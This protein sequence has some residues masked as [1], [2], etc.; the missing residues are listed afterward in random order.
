[1]GASFPAW[2]YA[3]VN[4]AWVPRGV[5]GYVVVGLGGL[6]ALLAMASV[7]EQAW[8][9]V[10]ISLGFGLLL[11]SAYRVFLIRFSNDPDIEVLNRPLVVITFINAVFVPVMAMYH[12]GFFDG[13]LG[14]FVAAVILWSAYY[15]LAFHHR[16]DEARTFVGLPSA[17]AVVGF[18]LS[19]FDATPVAAMTI[20][21]LVVVL[22]LV[23]IQWPHPFYAKRFPLLTRAV[24]L[25]WIGVAAVTLLTGFPAAPRAKTLLLAALAYGLVLSAYTF[26]RRKP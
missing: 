26:Q 8:E 11:V 25:L 15:R 14:L 2:E 19:A 13:W 12:A 1:M 16:P 3:P 4:G 6:S 20:A 24:L 23:P 21:G 7:L 22:C 10:Y 5:T 18:Y 17:W 9:R